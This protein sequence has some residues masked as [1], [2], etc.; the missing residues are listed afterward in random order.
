MVECQTQT[1][2][3][4]SKTNSLV[5]SSRAGDEFHYA[6]AARQCLR[7][8]NFNTTLTELSIEGASNSSDD[9]NIDAGE[10]VIDVGEYHHRENG[11]IDHIIYHQLKHSTSQLDKYFVPSDLE[12]TLSGFSRRFQEFSKKFGSEFSHEKLVFSFISNRLVDEKVKDAFCA[13]KLGKAVASGAIEK[14]LLQFTQMTF[15]EL[16]V[17]ASCVIFNDSEGD[18]LI[19]RGQLQ[20]ELSPLLA[21][22]LSQGL[23]DSLIAMVKDKALPHSARC[24]TIRKEDVLLRFGIT[25]TDE[26][27][28]AP[29]KLD[30]LSTYA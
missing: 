25:S 11:D 28:P 26:L 27:F 19:Q 1:S 7:L 10:Y 20:L 30:G 16:K 15:E 21:G 23:L 29:P 22:N 3:T 17:F 6:W 13:L 5:R 12:N 4:S 9:S 24:P 2:T 14:K 8:L 18:Y